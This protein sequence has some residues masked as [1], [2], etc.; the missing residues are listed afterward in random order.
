MA[1]VGNHVYV[2]LR[3]ASEFVAFRERVAD[4]VGGAVAGMMR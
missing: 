1:A 3:T 2:E 4:H